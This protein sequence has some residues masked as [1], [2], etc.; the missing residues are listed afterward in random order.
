MNLELDSQFQRDFDAK[1]AFADKGGS[2]WNVGVKFRTINGRLGISSLTIWS[3]DGNETLSRRALSDLPLLHLFRDAMA[4]ESQLLAQI[5]RPRRISTAHQGR[6]HSN[7][8]LQQVA[9]VYSIAYKA[10]LSVQKTVANAFGI[11]VSAAAKRIMVARSRGLIH[12]DK[13]GK[14]K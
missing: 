12:E 13:T 5:N 10:H 14:G 11:S 4:Q 6:V 8:E 2:E 3:K 7:A 9:D 1:A